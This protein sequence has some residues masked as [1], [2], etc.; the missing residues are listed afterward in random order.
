M[1]V[2][3]EWKARV[4]AVLADALRTE[5]ALQANLDALRLNLQEATSALLREHHAAGGRTDYAIRRKRLLA[6]VIQRQGYLDLDNEVRLL[7]AA[8]GCESIYGLGLDQLEIVASCLDTHIERA[9]V[10]ADHPDC[11]LAR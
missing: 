9:D 8:A 4:Q 11:A 6:R 3:T 1:A 10:A 2:S 7:V 5:A